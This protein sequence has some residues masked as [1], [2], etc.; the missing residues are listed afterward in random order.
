GVSRHI[1]KFIL[2]E[3]I[4]DEAG[5]IHAP[6]RWICRSIGVIEILL[7]QIETVLD[8]LPHLWWIT[9]ISANLTR[10]NRGIGRA[11]FL[12]SRVR[13]CRR[14]RSRL[15]SFDWNRRCGLLRCGSRGR[16]R[17]WLGGGRPFFTFRLRLRR[18]TGRW[19]W[20]GFLFR[21]RGRRWA[22][23]RLPGRAFPMFSRWSW[24]RCCLE[25]L[26]NFG[27]QRLFGSFRRSH[28]P[29]QD[30]DGE[31]EPKHCFDRRK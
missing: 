25:N 28:R 29:N 12:R 9:V 16:E 17:A 27:A 2:A 21:G 22:R 6:I 20:R 8:D 31:K 1:V 24:R 19:S 14:R 7:R 10:R 15:R 26:F 30:R 11:F 23:R 18:G 3:D 5:A 4:I 13:G